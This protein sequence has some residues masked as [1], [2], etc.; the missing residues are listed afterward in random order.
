MFPLPTTRPTTPRAVAESAIPRAAQV[1]TRAGCFPKL[2]RDTGPTSALPATP[3][4]ANSA[5]T[6][7]AT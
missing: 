4:S 3:E 5:V 2:V 7:P 1:N 6:A